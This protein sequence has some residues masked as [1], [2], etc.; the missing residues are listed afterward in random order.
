[1]SMTLPETADS[2]RTQRVWR[3]RTQD[4]EQDRK[5]FEPTWHEALAF[6]AGKQ[7]L[8]WDRTERRMIMPRD[9]RPLA[10]DLYTADR[11]GEYRMT[12]LGEMAADSDRPELLLVR[13]DEWSEELQDALNR[14]VQF[15]WDHDWHGDDSLMDARRLV[16][17][18]GTAGVRCRFDPTKGPVQDDNVPHLN[19]KPILDVNQAMQLM[20]QGAPLEF[21]PMREGRIVWEPLSPLNMLVPPG[22]PHERD[23]PWEVIVRPVLLEDVQAQFPE[24]AAGLKEDTDIMSLLGLDSKAESHT[25]VG[26]ESDPGSGQNRLRGHV[27]LLTGYEK[28]CAK[29]PEGR[30]VYLGGGE[31]KLL[32]AEDKLPNVAPNREPRSGISYLHW[33]RVTGRFW[34]RGL[35]EVM[36]DGQRRL[37]RRTTQAGKIIDRGQPKVFTKEGDLRHAPSGLPLEIVELKKDAAEPSFF[38]GIGPGPW[39]NEAIVQADQDL[40]HATGIYGPSRGENPQNV[41]TYSQLALIAEND[42]TKR[43]P[44]YQEHQSAIRSLVED[45]VY[46]IREFWGTSRKVIFED[47]ENQ[48]RG[49]AF[50]AAKVPDF[51]VVKVAKGT[52]R[53]KTQG[54]MLQLVND[55]K[56]AA[57]EAGLFG[58]PQWLDWYRESLEAGQPLD[59]PEV[60]ASNQEQLAE[61]ENHMLL[62]GQ[63][64]AAVYWDVAEIHVPVHRQAQDQAR[65][66][67][68]MGTVAAVEQHIQQ[69]IEAAMVAAQVA[70]Q[71][72]QPEPEQGEQP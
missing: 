69:H 24:A 44:I 33:W 3:Q 56:N 26:V 66:T 63:P 34:S 55:L 36:E 67:G 8:M 30:T 70:G 57:V 4:A 17:D 28:P 7:W 48:V 15:G 38:P 19:G 41:D 21:K 52:A 18:L 14:A 71:Q 43:Q 29:Y 42:Q 2:E 53:P 50:D 5:R 32:H 39:M 13:D 11:I 64:V 35:V 47:D 6:A 20:E 10:S 1:M 51:Y 9:L 60:P 72:G 37:N 49:L 54:A 12:A 62:E 16:I 68:D 59:F 31:R 61:I 46:N 25:T 27:W 40:A 45:S 58:G 23:F 22:V 65:L